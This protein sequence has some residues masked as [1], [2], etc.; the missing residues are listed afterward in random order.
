MTDARAAARVRA[1][2]VTTAESKA[3]PD[4]GFRWACSCGRTGNGRTAN[5]ARANANRHID[6]AFHRILREGS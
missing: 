3:R 4:G 6:A 2:H 5:K 1:E